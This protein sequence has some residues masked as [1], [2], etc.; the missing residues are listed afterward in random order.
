MYIVNMASGCI[1]EEA[2]YVSLDNLDNI[3]ILLDKWCN[4]FGFEAQIFKLIKS[5]WY[6][7]NAAL[8]LF[9]PV[10]PFALLKRSEN[11]WFSGGSKENLRKK[12]V[13][14]LLLVTAFKEKCF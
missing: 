5:Q 8:A 13:K 1:H 12:W 11:L 6:S 7:V 3:F 9:F 10:F 4:D 2:L 14:S